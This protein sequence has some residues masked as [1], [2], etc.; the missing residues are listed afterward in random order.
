MAMAEAS[1]VARQDRIIPLS[2]LAA[3]FVPVRRLFSAG[4][5]A[6]AV[7]SGYAGFQKSHQR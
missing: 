3:P 4:K 1:A 7:K 5:R 6:G 2:R